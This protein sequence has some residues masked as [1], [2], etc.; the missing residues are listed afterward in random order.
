LI[1]I[2]SEA[3]DLKN[4]NMDG[5]ITV[6]IIAAAI[7]FK[8]VG[9]N[10][11][12]AAGD[13]VFPHIPFEPEDLPS[14]EEDDSVEVPRPQVVVKPQVV[15]RPTVSEKP[16][17]EEAQ[18]ALPAKQVQTKPSVRKPEVPILVEEEPQEKEK[19]DPKKLVIY[20]E[21]MKPKYLE[22]TN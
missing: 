18:R 10:F 20:S 2:L 15:E 16:L 22:E 21:I 12:S 1:V 6:L 14:A 4:N 11:K 19:I 13:E 5:L 9:K 17:F 8:V 3:K 7:I